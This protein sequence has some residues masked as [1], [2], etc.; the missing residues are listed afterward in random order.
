MTRSKISLCFKY[1]VS[2]QEKYLKHNTLIKYEIENNGFILTAY[3]KN[4]LSTLIEAADL[5]LN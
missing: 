5:T 3:T 2:F 4:E 1:N